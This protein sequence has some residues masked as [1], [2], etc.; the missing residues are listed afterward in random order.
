MLYINNLRCTHD[1]T[2]CC[3]RQARDTYWQ[4]NTCQHLPL[5]RVWGMQNITTSPHMHSERSLHS[6]GN[7]K[8]PHCDSEGG[9]V[10]SVVTRELRTHA[11]LFNHEKQLPKFVSLPKKIKG[12]FSAATTRL[13]ACVHVL[14]AL[15]LAVQLAMHTHANFVKTNTRA[16]ASLPCMH[17]CMAFVCMG[18]W[19]VHML[20]CMHARNFATLDTAGLKELSTRIQ[21][22]RKN[23]SHFFARHFLLR[24]TVCSHEF[25]RDFWEKTIFGCV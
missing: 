22:M 1:D 6:Q 12:W 18:F 24:I 2:G 19:H 20:A 14:A 3:I 25:L 13:C 23:L 17:M 4:V 5:L 11:R 21:Q 7:R 16:R 9:R 10:G 8:E 15:Q